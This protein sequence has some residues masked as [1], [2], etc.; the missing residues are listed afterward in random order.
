[1]RVIF[2][3]VITKDAVGIA[4]LPNHYSTNAGII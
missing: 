1:M 3:S 4:F 2:T